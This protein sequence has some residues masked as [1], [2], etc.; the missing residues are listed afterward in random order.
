M[1]EKLVKELFELCEKHQLKITTAESCTGGL[2]AKIITD[3]SGSSK[4][5]QQGFITYSN[6]A[7]ISLLKVK[8]TTIGS[9]GAVSMQVANQMALGTLSYFA[10]NDNIISI[11]TTGIA[12]P[13]GGTNSKPV[14]LVYMSVAN[15]NK[16]G[17]FRNKFSGTRNSIRN[18]T[19]IMA[20]KLL[21]N[22]I[23]LWKI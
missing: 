11:S 18:Q 1:N 22:Q 4:Y 6:E 17:C 13:D 15:G 20:L 19:S 10:G 9:Y 16:V 23:K 8:S 2:I 3:V 12:G 14:G 7:K 21:I 5:F